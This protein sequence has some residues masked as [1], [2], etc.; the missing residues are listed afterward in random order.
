MVVSAPTGK[1]RVPLKELFSAD[2]NE[3]FTDMHK[4]SYALIMDGKGFAV[5]DTRAAIELVHQIRNDPIGPALWHHSL[6][7]LFK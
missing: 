3:G 7:H 1:K 5:E 6:R 2:F 4:A